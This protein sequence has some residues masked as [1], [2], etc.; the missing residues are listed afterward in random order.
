MKDRII[1]PTGKEPR[2]YTRDATNTKWGYITY[3]ANDKGIVKPVR[4]EDDT[5]I[6]PRYGPLVHLRGRCAGDQ[7]VIQ[8]VK[9]YLLQCVA[10][11]LP[12]LLQYT[13]IFGMIAT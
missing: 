10:I 12:C 9:R 4:K 5:L 1:V 13:A 11:S 2:I 3:E 8:G 7:V 6:A